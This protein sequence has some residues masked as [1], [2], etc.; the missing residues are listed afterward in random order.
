[1][2]LE[3]SHFVTHIRVDAGES[4]KLQVKMRRKSN[5]RVHLH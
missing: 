3:R 2:R 1:M 5:L 4:E